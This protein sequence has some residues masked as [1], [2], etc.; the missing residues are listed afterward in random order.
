MLTEKELEK[1]LDKIMSRLDEVNTFFIA[2]VA[3][4]IKQIGELNQSSINRL[5]IMVDMGTAI[6]EINRRLELAT[7]LNTRDLFTL[8]QAAL[9]DVYTDPRF[10]RMLTQQPISQ[11]AQTRLTLYTQNVAVQTAKTMQNLSNTT[12]VSTAYQ[13]AIDKAI[14]AV[15][16]GVTD[17]KSATRDA[18]RELGYNGMQVRYAS[19]YHR[20]LDTA[21]RQNIIDGVNQIAQNGSIMMGE[22][23]GY[24]AYEISAHANSAPDHEPVQGRV[25]LKSEFAKMQMG[26]PCV[27]VDGNQY[28]G[29]E[30]NIGEWNCMHIVMSFS[31]EHS[32]RRYTDE[33]LQAF[34]RDNHKGCEIDGKHYTLYKA[35]QLMRQIETETRREK[36]A[37]NAARIAGN[38]LARADSQKRINALTAK[39]NKICAASGLPARRDRMRVEGFRAV[40]I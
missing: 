14:F 40:K 26:L 7:G 15:S 24:D 39:Y 11:E 36:D 30:R 32:K 27:D 29:F 17:Y 6:S 28:A 3:A 18:I 25:F 20:R 34:E 35:R 4:Q 31:T 21:V 8:Y 38:D 12:A 5:N 16:T 33:E 1:A 22:A 19:G 13:D 37:A 10:S 23:L 2:K 9:T